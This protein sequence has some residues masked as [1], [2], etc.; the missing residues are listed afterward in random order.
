MYSLSVRR[1][2]FLGD[3]EFN[4]AIDKPAKLAAEGH[5]NACVDRPQV[6][7]TP[8]ISAARLEYTPRLLE[9]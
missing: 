3:F 2:L 5:S 1:M 8:R 9:Q 4:E 6:L 7:R